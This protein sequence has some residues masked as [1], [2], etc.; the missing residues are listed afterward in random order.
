V[1]IS[2]YRGM[3][4]FQARPALA[5]PVCIPGSYTDGHLVGLLAV[6][7]TGEFPV[8]LLTTSMGSTTIGQLLKCQ[9]RGGWR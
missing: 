1:A 4:S 6:G 5:D 9:R 3:A 7:D 8:R 2:L